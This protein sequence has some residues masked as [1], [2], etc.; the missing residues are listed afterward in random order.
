MLRVL[1]PWLV[2]RMGAKSFNMQAFQLRVLE[3]RD[4]LS[5]RLYKLTDYIKGNHFLTLD[6]EN[7]SLLVKQSTAMT[8][9]LNALDQRIALF[10]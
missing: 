3:E 5:D 2:L 1:R 9:Y 7:Q 10:K 6:L 4:Q 8:A